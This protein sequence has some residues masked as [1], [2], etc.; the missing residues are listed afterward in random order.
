MIPIKRRSILDHKIKILG[1]IECRLKKCQFAQEI[2]NNILKHDNAVSIQ[3]ML[4]LI[5]EKSV[6]FYS[7]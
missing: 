5:L 2:N 3:F 1:K 4:M 7:T 6:I